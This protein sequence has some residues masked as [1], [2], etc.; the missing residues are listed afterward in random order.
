MFYSSKREKL[1][2]LKEYV[3]HM[4]EGQEKIYYATGNS[5]SKIDSLPQVEQVK[6]KDYDILYLTDYID[7]FVLSAIHEYEKKAFVN[8]EKDDLDLGTEEEK[9][10]TKKV[11]EENNE[12]LKEMQKTI[13]E[14]QEVRFTNKLKSHP[15]CLTSVGEISIEMQK[16]FEAMPNTPNMKAQTVL[17]I[18]EKHPIVNKLKDLYQNDKETF[19]KYTKILYS[20]ARMIAGLPIENPTEV[21]NLICD[22]IAK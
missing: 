10:E 3:E 12:M 20:E 18:N 5:I 4:K 7:E 16:V 22:V 6:E 11:N 21:S 17:E 14:V 1:V 15:V 8:I 2:T 13:E 9:E 19:E